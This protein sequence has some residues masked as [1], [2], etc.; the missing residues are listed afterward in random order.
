[1]EEGGEGKEKE[2]KRTAAK[3]LHKI[4]ELDGVPS[5]QLANVIRKIHLNCQVSCSRTHLSAYTCSHIYV[6]V[7]CSFKLFKYLQKNMPK[8]KEGKINAL[9]V[10]R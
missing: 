5:C 10:L 8:K 1:M 7:Y 2:S 9:V 3:V 6:R 4:N